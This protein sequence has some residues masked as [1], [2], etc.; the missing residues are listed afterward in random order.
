MSENITPSEHL[1]ARFTRRGQL[2]GFQQMNIAKK[3]AKKYEFLPPPL[4]AKLSTI[5]GNC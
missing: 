4:P 3:F 2:S 1:P 5:T